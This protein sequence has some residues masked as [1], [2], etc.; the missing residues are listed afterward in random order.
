MLNE[1]CRHAIPDGWQHELLESQPPLPK[2]WSCMI[3]RGEERY[4]GQSS[5]SPEAAMDAAVGLMRKAQRED[6]TR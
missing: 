1:P 3:W 2:F 6:P 4:R 5:E